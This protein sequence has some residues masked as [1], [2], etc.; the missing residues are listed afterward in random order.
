[1]PI[2]SLDS[3]AMHIILG[4]L[5]QPLALDKGSQNIYD[6]DIDSNGREVL[7]IGIW[8]RCLYKQAER[9]SKRDLAACS[10]VSRGWAGATRPHLFRTVALRFAASGQPRTIDSINIWLKSSSINTSGCIKK[11]RLLM[12]H[13][14]CSLWDEPDGSE[15]SAG[16]DFCSLVTLAEILAKCSRLQVLELFEVRIRY[17]LQMSSFAPHLVPPLGRPL[18][19]HRLYW[20]RRIHHQDS[21]NDFLC[22]LSWLG[23]VE[24]FYLYEF[25]RH[26]IP[27]TAIDCD[28]ELL[29]APTTMTARSLSILFP[30]HLPEF[31]KVLL[32]STIFQPHQLQGW[33][34]PCHAQQ[35]HR[36]S[37]SCRPCSAL[38][39]RGWKS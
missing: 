22:V 4:C 1:M 35:I 3:D 15:D 19:L 24:T 38:Y 18:N 26:R 36:S 32:E 31:L 28:G 39:L 6:R 10:L 33:L 14:A 37:N 2:S 11:L 27:G 25:G 5:S 12:L 9:E 17:E 20:E 23:H 30:S 7:F 21:P 29:I 16:R 13:K 34:S 8:D